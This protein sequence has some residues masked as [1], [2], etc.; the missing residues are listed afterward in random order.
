M[1]PFTIEKLWLCLASGG[2]KEISASQEAGKLSKTEML[3]PL[4]AHKVMV[5]DALFC[6]IL[7]SLGW[8]RFAKTVHKPL[9]ILWEFLYVQY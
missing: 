8:L 4:L 7:S 1:L 5:M 6:L 9:G 2:F 3:S